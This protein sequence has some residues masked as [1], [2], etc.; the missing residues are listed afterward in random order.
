MGGTGQPLADSKA[1]SRV[2]VQLPYLPHFCFP[3][4][5]ILLPIYLNFASHLPLFCFPSTSI[6]L[7]IS[8]VFKRV[9]LDSE[10][11]IPLSFLFVRLKNHQPEAGK[12]HMGASPMLA[13]R[14]QSANI[15]CHQ[16]ECVPDQD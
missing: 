1:V 14:A 10:V 8:H 4:T 13:F 6:W 7:P 11:H 2:G 5:S 3:S 9:Q 16:A 15:S 12:H